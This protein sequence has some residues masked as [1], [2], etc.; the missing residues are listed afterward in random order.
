MAKRRNFQNPDLDGA[1]FFWPGKPTGILLI[2]GFTAT[3]VEIRPLAEYFS[4]AGFSVAGPLLPGHNTSAEDLNTRLWQ[5]WVAAV[6]QSYQMLRSTCER[7]I[8]GGESLGGLL[9]LH[10]ASLHPEIAG[11]LVYSPALRTKNIRRARIARFFLPMLAKG[12]SA[13]S[14]EPLPWQGYTDFPV[15]AAYQLYL[16]QRIVERR[17]SLVKQPALIFQGEKDRRI[18]SNSSPIILDAIAST[19]KELV[20][21]KNSGHCVVID[22]EYA[23]VMAHSLSFVQSILQ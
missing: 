17:L 15:K 20:W 13:D 5:E 8:V 6:D 19:R 12:E 9:T 23:E 7:V 3:T 14:K 1:A 11:L 18:E 2:H 4:R 22:Q 16:F 10:L 21:M